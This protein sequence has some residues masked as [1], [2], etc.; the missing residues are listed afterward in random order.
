MSTVKKNKERINHPFMKKILSSLFALATTSGF[1]CSPYLPPLVSHTITPSTIDF[2]VI[3]TSQ[4]QCCFV[5]EMELVCEGSDFTGIANLQPGIE[6]CK[7]AGN[8]SASSWGSEPYPVYSFPSSDLCPGVPYKYRVRDRHTGY[9]YWSEWS[10]IGF[11]TID[12]TAPTFELTLTADPLVICAPDCSTI[13]ATYSEGC[14]PPILTWNQGLSSASEHLVCPTENTLYEVS[15]SFAIPYCP[16]VTQTQFVNIVAD[17]PAV[18]G[19]LT[20]SPPALCLGESTTITISGYYGALQWQSSTVVGGPFVDIPGATSTTFVY[21]SAVAGNIYFRVRVNT[22]SE[23]F[24]API[25]ILVYDYPQTDFSALDVCYTEPVVFENLTQNIFPIT[26]WGWNFGDGNT[27]TAESPMHTFAPG[28]YQVTLTATN[29][30]GCSNSTSNDITVYGAPVVSFSANPL[31]GFEPLVVDF[32]N[33]SI[34]ATNYT[35]NFG[36]GNSTFG[37]F[38]QTSHTFE[39]YGTYTVTLSAIENGCSD[40]A[41]LTI[42]VYINDITYQIPNVFTPS[43]GDD[44]NS[45]F[46]L[47]NPM[48]F[49]RIE[50]FEVIIMNRWGQVLRTYDNYDFGWDGKND[51]GIDVPEGVYFYKLYIL[52]VQGETFENHGFVHLIRE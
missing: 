13:T 27:S 28:T 17:L 15:A 39:N 5:F 40:T 2:Q 24:T 29:A 44:V 10:A 32:I 33:T 8:A 6:V 12:G 14:S 18:A 22:C 48:G 25:L 11:F 7:G 9:N 51:S 4:W 31:A 47:I 23:E 37:N 41:T 34:G 52:S 35:W 1:A 38:I 50:D 42:V 45:Y 49:N 30:G 19:T 21:N 43:S 46:Q 3:S 26:E 36:D 16:S 20:A